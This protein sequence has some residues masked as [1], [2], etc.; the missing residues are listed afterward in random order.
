M[1]GSVQCGAGAVALQ[2]GLF[3]D[4]RGVHAKPPSDPSP[5]RPVLPPLGPPVPGRPARG[6]SQD[7]PG[8]RR[9]LQDDT[10]RTQRTGAF[11][12][13]PLGPV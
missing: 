13:G 4:P 11:I 7:V 3:K 12:E 1:G 9:A 2:P 8:T 10:L 5:S 6:P